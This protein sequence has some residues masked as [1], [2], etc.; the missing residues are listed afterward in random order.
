MYCAIYIRKSREEKDKPSHRLNVQREQL[1]A[2]ATTQG[3][4]FSIYDD[5]HASAARGKVEHLPE[6]SR[7]ESDI[8]SGKINIILCIEL[9]RLSRD[10]TMQDYIAWLTLCADHHVK[11]ATMSRT[12]DP[13]QHSD[14]MLL[15]MEG[16]FSSVEMK[17]LQARM[18][19]GRAQA[20]NAGKFLGGGCPPPYRYD[21]AQGKPVIDAALLTQAQKVWKLAETISAR[22]LALTLEMPFISTRRML[23]DD[24][25]LF[26]QALRPDLEG[27]E[28][29]PCDW[30]PCL[31][32]EQ[33]ERIRT[34]RRTGYKGP[35]RT[36]GGLL[37]NLGL[38]YCG[39]CAS[40]YRGFKGQTRQDGTWT[41]YYGCQG[42]VH[43][44]KC[45]R[46]HMIEQP[47]IDNRVIIN[48]LGVLD[49]IPVLKTAWEKMKA[50]GTGVNR[51]Q[52][53]AQEQNQLEI[54]KQR[55]MA[56]IS[57]GVIDFADAKPQMNTIKSALEA[58]KKEKTTTISTPAEN[59]DWD[60]LEAVRD[61]FSTLA[62]E[63]QREIISS[64]IKKIRA[65]STY[66]IVEY[67]F[68]I[69]DDGIATTRIH[70][71]STKH[72]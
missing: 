32:A 68:P 49:R 15:L 17:V 18:K 60:V 33:A 1:P 29:I 3:W 24:R 10:D 58:L 25:L 20:Y 45:P 7:L 31:T 69:A 51:L 55:L 67:R 4:Q 66:L 52:Q 23:A 35:R 63:E 62:P 56:A 44:G 12:L 46:S 64:A 57:E 36:F 40:T 2:Y 5:G 22:K 42:K 61:I 21:K 28:P 13:S 48:L 53:I 50:N 6:R 16:G 11:L 59:P 19:E 54:K 14:W 72:N 39:Y 70:L 43:K 65:Y 71:P 41:N 9:S 27:G 37:S 38:V 34:A 26:C 8:R 30:E 47:A